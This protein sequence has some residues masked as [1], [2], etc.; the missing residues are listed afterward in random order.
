MEEGKRM[1]QLYD[2]SGRRG[3]IKEKVNERSVFWLSIR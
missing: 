3:R 1:K 2:R